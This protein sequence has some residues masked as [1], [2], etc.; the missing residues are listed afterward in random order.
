MCKNSAY[1][2]CLYSYVF[3]FITLNLFSVIQIIYD[4]TFFCLFFQKDVLESS[5]Y[6]LIFS[7]TL[8]F[9]ILM[10]CTSSDSIH[11]IVIFLSLSFMKN[12]TTMTSR[13]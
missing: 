3:I 7:Y 4:F 2:C 13:L 6:Y 10:I 8:L 12:M 1:L 9:D 5:K 11:F